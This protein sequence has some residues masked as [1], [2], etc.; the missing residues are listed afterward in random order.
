MRKRLRVKVISILILFISALILLFC[1]EPSNPFLNPAN[2]TIDMVIPDTAN[3]VIYTIDT[4]VIKI[5]VT[6]V[7]CIDSVRL[8]VGSYYDSLF[9]EIT[10]TMEVK[11]V[12]NDT[13]SIAI[14][15]VAYCQG[16][17]TKECRKSLPVYKNPL[18]P[19]SIVN[20]QALSDTTVKLYW[21][22]VSV[23]VSYTVYRSVSDTGTFTR[24]QSVVDTFYI[25]SALS[26]AT[27]YYYKASS[28]D[29]LNRESDL[30][31]IYSATTMDVLVSKWDA[32]VW[33]RDKWH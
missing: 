33:D 16:G 17:L 7:S 1:S 13:G 26:P 31:S 14:Q 15:A 32:M 10:D 2:V 20:T 29:S 27:T 25:D 24:I 6:L 8:T 3:E 19:P 11:H 18:V 21:E 9:T 5:V 30:S 23:A 4:N 28:I 12:F 22:S